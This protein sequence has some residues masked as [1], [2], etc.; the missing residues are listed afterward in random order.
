MTAILKKARIKRNLTDWLA[1][2]DHLLG[3]FYKTHV[4]ANFLCY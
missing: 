1:L 3:S 4:V 2:L